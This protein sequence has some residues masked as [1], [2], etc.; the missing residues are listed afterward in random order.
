[1]FRHAFATE[2]LSITIS[3]NLLLTLF[4]KHETD[5]SLVRFLERSLQALVFLSLF[6][7]WKVGYM[8]FA[9]S[10]ERKQIH[11]IRSGTYLVKKERWAKVSHGS[12]DTS[13]TVS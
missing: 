1:M 9:G 11:M 13:I 5:L 4:K 6:F 10:D 3:N 8:P 12:N 2:T 7:S